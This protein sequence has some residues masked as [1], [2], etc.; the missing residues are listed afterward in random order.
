VRRPTMNDFAPGSTLAAQ[1]PEPAGVARGRVLLVEDDPEVAA[2]TSALLRHFGWRVTHAP[3][4]ECAL[5]LIEAGTVAIDVVLAD[6]AMPGAFDG[7][8]LAVHLRRMHPELRVVLMTGRTTEVHR[9]AWDGFE[10]LPKPCPPGLL[11]RTL[12]GMR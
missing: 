2:A 12:A 8:E 9:A 3:G 7:M 4:A 10:L 11:D 5:D 6:I 1:T